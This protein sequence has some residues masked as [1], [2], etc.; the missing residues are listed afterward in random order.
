MWY[1]QLGGGGPGESVAPMSLCSSHEGSMAIPRRQARVSLMLDCQSR[2]YIVLS[3]GE[4][5]KGEL[6]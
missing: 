5:N 2:V 6:A 1:R 4:I 3:H